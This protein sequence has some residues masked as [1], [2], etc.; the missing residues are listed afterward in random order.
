[1]GRDL[2][3]ACLRPQLP[4]GVASSETKL[5]AIH[6]AYGHENPQGWG[7]GCLEQ[8]VHH[9]NGFPRRE[10]SGFDINHVY[11]VAPVQVQQALQKAEW[12]LELLP[13]QQQALATPA[14]SSRSPFFASFLR[15]GSSLA[16]A[17]SSTN[18]SRLARASSANSRD[19]EVQGGGRN[20]M[21]GADGSRRAALSSGRAGSGGNLRKNSLKQISWWS[22]TQ[23]RSRAAATAQ[24]AEQ[25]LQP[26]YVGDGM[27]EGSG[28]SMTPSLLEE[29]AALRSVSQVTGHPV[30]THPGDGLVMQPKVASLDVLNG[31]TSS[32]SR[33]GVGEEPDTAPVK[34]VGDS[35]SGG[36]RRDSRKQLKGPGVQ[37]Q[38]QQAAVPLHLLPAN[39]SFTEAESSEA[40][41]GAGDCSAMVA[42][43]MGGEAADP[44]AAAAA[45]LIQGLRVR[46]GVA[47]G[48]LQEGQ[49]I[50]SSRVLDVA[51]GGWAGWTAHVFSC[52]PPALPTVGSARRRPLSQVLLTGTL[53][54]ML[55]AV[56]HLT[57]T[58]AQPSALCT[59][60]PS[61]C[62]CV[63]RSG[64]RCRGG[65]PGAAGWPHL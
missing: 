35:Q 22:G 38:Q 39:S 8:P 29:V 37:Q 9:V 42:A 44:L 52:R 36:K 45:E 46:I 16:A 12:P 21:E 61:P 20:S 55:F 6:H 3:S 27:V 51:K 30:T 57:H 32:S 56:H 1:V 14:A 47:T 19:A 43:G 58:H 40:E 50:T 60:T 53:L 10:T 11:G 4:L 33:V 64:Q 17:P 23:Q 26:R 65:W 5:Y 18:Q 24:Q 2:F 59:P 54:R 15:R 34:D 13:V 7:T 62:C 28:A 49:D 31:S 63:Q 48:E 41:M 25:P